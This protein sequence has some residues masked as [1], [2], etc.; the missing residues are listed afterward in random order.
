MVSEQPQLRVT[1]LARDMIAFVLENPQVDLCTCGV[2]T[3]GHVNENLSASGMK[4]TPAGRRRLEIAAATPCP[5]AY[6][7]WLENDWR[8]T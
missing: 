2:H 5:G 4:L 6:H 8:Q 7:A 3:L 1:G